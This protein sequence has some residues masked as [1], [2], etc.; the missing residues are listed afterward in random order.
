MTYIY[1]GITYEDWCRSKITNDPNT[2]EHQLTYSKYDDY[3]NYL[4]QKDKITFSIDDDLG[5]IILPE[6][7]KLCKQ[8]WSVLK[9]MVDAHLEEARRK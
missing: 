2:P 1:E 5:K 9:R 6:E 3:L 8:T 4:K 7:Y